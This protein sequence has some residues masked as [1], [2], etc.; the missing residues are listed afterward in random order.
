VGC[1]AHGGARVCRLFWTL[2]MSRGVLRRALSPQYN[3]SGAPLGAGGNPQ[4][5]VKSVSRC[6][7]GWVGVRSVTLQPSE[8]EVWSAAFRPYPA[9]QIRAKAR[10]PNS[11][12]HPRT[13]VGSPLHSAEVLLRS[14]LSTAHPPEAYL[15]SARV[16]APGGRR[17]RRDSLGPSWPSFLGG[18]TR[19]RAFSLTKR[20]RAR[21]LGGLSTRRMA[22]RAARG[23]ANQGR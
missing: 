22:R 5:A 17:L 23:D 16:P 3:E 8:V 7:L 20:L 1:R 21:K 11:A 10:T 6:G 12:R 18:Q 14:L 13:T 2:L 19:V 9:P 4:G 15:G